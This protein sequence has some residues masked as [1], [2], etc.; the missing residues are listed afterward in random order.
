M[1]ET[2]KTAQPV[3]ST[4]LPP[5][6]YSER[7]GSTYMVN[8]SLLLQCASAKKTVVLTDFNGNFLWELRCNR[9]ASYRAEFIPKEKLAPI[10]A[11]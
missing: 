11:N 4:W 9:I 1:E 5:Q 10:I 7:M 2:Q 8:D 3:F 6:L